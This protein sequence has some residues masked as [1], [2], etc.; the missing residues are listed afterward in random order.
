MTTREASEYIREYFE[1]YPRVREFLDAMV[2]QGRERGY[3]TTILGRRRYLPGLAAREAPVR[4]F[5][6]R[7]A[8]NTP[9]QGSAADLIKLAMLR[10]HD[11]L[12][13]DGHGARMLLQVHD[14]LLVEA[15]KTDAE[16]VAAL[17]REC[18]EGVWTLA[19]PLEV[20]VA[21]GESWA[22]VH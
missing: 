20:E 1:R 15:P 17:L 4:Q 8:V 12:A 18:M 3:V 9:V 22:E 16:G 7:A 5:A 6:E 13:R 10:V 19:V 2:A 14:E 21:V 11:R